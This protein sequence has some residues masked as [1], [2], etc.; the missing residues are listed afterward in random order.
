MTPEPAASLLAWFAHH[1]R[2]TLPWR[3][4]REPYAI[5]VSEFM[6]QQTQVE[7]VIPAF[8]SFLERFPGFGALARGSRADV[9]RAWKGLGYNGRAIR[10]HE[11]GRVVAG[12]SN[13]ALP[14]DVASL[15]ALPGIGAYT[16]A[17]VAAFAFDE[18]VI[19]VDTNVKRIVHRYR[20]GVE[21]PP[22]ATGTELAAEARR[23]L[24]PGSA[25]AFNS[26]LM[27]LGATIC[28]ARTPRCLVC[29]LRRSCAA[30]PLEASRIAALAQAHRGRRSPQESVAFVRSTRYL[31]GRVIDR[32]RALAPEE[33]ISLLDLE[34]E[35]SAAIEPHGS[36]TFRRI[37]ADLA[38]E[39]ALE[40]TTGTVCLPH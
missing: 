2:S 1:G 8:E 28:T 17:A 26:A 21:W 5:V 7:R 22:K 13:G 23:W 37:V 10:L 3:R 35:L 40:E 11:L 4:N 18:D 32:L 9:L 19:A 6:L 14:R 20:F 34:S 30:A 12:R 38:R 31:R 24:P 25:Y 36:E 16:A 15:R 33:R 27:D 39:G 29:P